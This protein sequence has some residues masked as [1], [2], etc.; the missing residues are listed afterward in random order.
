[1]DTVRLQGSVA[2]G[3]EVAVEVAPAAGGRLASIR[4]DDLELLVGAGPAIGP[5]H[6][7]CYPMAPF[8]G[9][10][11][12]GRF[13]FGGVEHHLPRAMPPHAIHGTAW[14]ARWEV[15][16]PGGVVG[17]RRVRLRHELGPPWPWPGHVVHDVELGAEGLRLRLEVHAAR[18]A[19]PVTCGWHPWFRRRLARGGP[20]ELELHVRRWLPKGP[21]GLPTGDHRPVPP[22]PGEGWDDCFTGVVAP[23]SVRWP[24]ALAVTLESDCDHLVV[25]DQPAHALCVEPQ[26]GPPDGLRLGPDVAEPGAPVLA[27]VL[28]RFEPA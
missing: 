27:E 28:L 1:M 22:R 3:H 18:S 20:A 8:A 17:D 4:V 26:T 10:V 6:W 12:W 7:G 23:P 9:R 16:P 25:Y 19:M 21:D 5:F 11:G 2:S 15:D 13:R 24:G 14:G